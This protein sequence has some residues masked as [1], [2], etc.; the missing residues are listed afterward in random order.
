MGKDPKGGDGISRLLW[1]EERAGAARQLTWHVGKE[2]R[3]ILKGRAVSLRS[4]RTSCV[5][6]GKS[7][8]CEMGM[9]VTTH[10]FIMKLK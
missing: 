3:V 6:L 2:E 10:R 5:T 9:I 7:L 8:L 4:S 1:A